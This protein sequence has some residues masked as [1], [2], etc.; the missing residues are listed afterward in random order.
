[1]HHAILNKREMY[2]LPRKFN[3]AFDGGGKVAALDDTNDIG[4]F[5]VRVPEGKAVPAGIYFRLRLGGITGHHDFAQDE[6][7]VLRPDQCVKVAEAI[8][9]VF[10]EEGDRTNR[11]KGAS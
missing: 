8:V 2:G 10:A 3:I 5:A 1:M 9:R 7:V 6:G 11:Q 4:F